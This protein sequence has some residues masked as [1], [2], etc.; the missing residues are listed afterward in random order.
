MR[1]KNHFHLYVF[2]TK[3]IFPKSKRLDYHKLEVF[4]LPE[5]Q[6]YKYNCQ[7]QLS[8]MLIVSRLLDTKIELKIILL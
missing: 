3:I 1:D 6:I 2:E 7:R 4:Q 5:D 8:R